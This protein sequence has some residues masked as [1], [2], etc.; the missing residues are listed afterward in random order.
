MMNH[1]FL[2]P[3]MYVSS[4][5]FTSTTDNDSTFP[6]LWFINPNDHL[7]IIVD[8]AFSTI[9]TKKLIFAP[10]V[11]EPLEPTPELSED[12]GTVVATQIDG[13]PR[14]KAQEPRPRTTGQQLSIH[15]DAD[16]EN[17]DDP[18][19]PPHQRRRKKKAV[20]PPAEDD[21]DGEWVN[22]M[23]MIPEKYGVKIGAN[24]EAEEADRKKRAAERTQ[25]EKYKDARRK[26]WIGWNAMSEEERKQN[27]ISG[28][29]RVKDQGQIRGADV[30]VRASNSTTVMP[31]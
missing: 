18:T 3:G 24:Y 16:D 31:L 8:Y 23:S 21:S 19:V 26:G 11:E 7:Q 13:A 22:P 28:V 12:E 25:L 15:E 30:I 29:G 6:K 5:F 4:I 10:P 1:E 9:A 2:D 14:K 20:Q 17:D 27:W